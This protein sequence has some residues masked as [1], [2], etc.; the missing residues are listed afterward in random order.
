[1]IYS[2]SEDGILTLN[3]DG[4]DVYYQVNFDNGSFD[5]YIPSD[6]FIGKYTYDELEINVFGEY[7]GAGRYFVSYGGEMGYDKDEEGNVTYYYDY[8]TIMMTLDLEAG[9]ITFDEMGQTLII[10]PDGTLATAADESRR[11]RYLN[12]MSSTWSNIKLLFTVTD[13]QNE[14]FNELYDLVLNSEYN[15]KLYEAYEAFHELVEEIRMNG[16]DLPTNPGDSF[17]VVTPSD[18]N[19]YEVSYGDIN[20]GYAT[21]GG[22]NGYTMV[23]D[24]VEYTYA[25]LTPAA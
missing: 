8:V 24:G 14:R 3:L 10:L 16:I 2:L 7:N 19:K 13:E 23:V 25:T 20:G 22:E 5:Q 9:T 18:D 4:V 11:E 6:S 15:E 17:V 12:D 21:I 1:M